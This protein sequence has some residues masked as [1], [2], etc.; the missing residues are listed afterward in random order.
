VLVAAA[1]AAR[2]RGRRTQGAPAAQI[3]G[4]WDEYVDAAVDSGRDAPPVLTRSE[5]AEGW[6]TASGEALARDA[7]R[8]VFSGGPV[9]SEDARA[10]WRVVDAERAGLARERGVWRGVL[11]SVSLR[12]FVR[13]LAP[14]GTRPRFAER[15]KRR[16]TQPA[17]LSP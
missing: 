15:G 6:G 11:A 5:L 7:D 9:S 1:K 13:H 14:P 3:A 16:V 12:S 2:R 4:G 8:A 10:F 17:R